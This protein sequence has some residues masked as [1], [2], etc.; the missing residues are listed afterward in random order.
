M[1]QSLTVYDL[2]VLRGWTYGF[3]TNLMWQKDKE[4][5]DWQMMNDGGEFLQFAYKMGYNKPMSPFQRMTHEEYK[6]RFAQ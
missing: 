3:T 2:P 6:Q 4:G 1:K 5:T